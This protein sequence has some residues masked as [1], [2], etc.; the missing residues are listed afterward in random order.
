MRPIEDMLNAFEMHYAGITYTPGQRA[1]LLTKYSWVRSG[2]KIAVYDAVTRIHE[3]RFR[4]LPDTAAIERAMT[5]LERP[6]V[7]DKSAEQLALPEPGSVDR[8]EDVSHITAVLTGHADAQ[9]KPEEQQ[10]INHFERE[11]IRVRVLK[12]NATPAEAF[13]I[14]CIDEY[15]GDWKTARLAE[16]KPVDDF[17]TSGETVADSAN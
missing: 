6:E 12:G 7:Y 9:R 4:T 2:Y 13:W 10:E 16:C 15:G 14:R 17:E 5:S 11:R 3:A 1:E 8:S